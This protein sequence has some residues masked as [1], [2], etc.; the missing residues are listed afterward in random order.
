MS[1]D[2]IQFPKPKPK[3]ETE[4]EYFARKGAQR[5]EF[6]ERHTEDCE[7]LNLDAY[8]KKLDKKASIP[9][10]VILAIIGGLFCMTIGIVI[11]IYIAPT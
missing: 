6:F 1:A 3:E 7:D 2:I 5:N 10:A 9:I 4:N 8:L 11:G